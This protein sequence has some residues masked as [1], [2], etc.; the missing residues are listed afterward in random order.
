[1]LVLMQNAYR[2]SLGGQTRVRPLIGQQV[3]GNTT[4]ASLR[5]SFPE[6]PWHISTAM[7]TMYLLTRG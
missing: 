2:L 7:H 6:L 4:P 1:M 5:Y 3:G